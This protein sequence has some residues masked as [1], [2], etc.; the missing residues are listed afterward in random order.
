MAR[1]IRE[2]L[3]SGSGEIASAQR[4]VEYLETVE[5]YNRWAEVYDTDGNFLQALDSIE[6]QRLLPRLVAKVAES[7]PVRKLVDLGCGTGRNTRR[8]LEFAPQDAQVVGVDASPGMLEVARATIN[9]EMEVDAS[10][11]ERV[12]LDIYDLLQS[13]PVPPECSKEASGVISTLVLEHIPVAQFFEG[14]AALISSGG[15]FLLT[16]M[17]SDMGSISQAGFVDTATGTKIRPTSYSHTIEEV[18]KAAE[19]A[20]FD[21]VELDGEQVRERKVDETMV[22]QLGKRA[23][24]WVGVTVWFGICFRKRE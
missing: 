20:G 16:N 17:H 2:S 3:A 22:E 12:L 14:V 5:A 13:P 24:K 23:N 8:L 21:V 9:K 18:L 1:T 15:Y 6:M 10:G 7:G 11:S 4:P 19:E